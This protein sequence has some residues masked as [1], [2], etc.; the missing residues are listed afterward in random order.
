MTE[1]QLEII[2]K[3]VKEIICHQHRLSSVF[4]VN[5]KNQRGDLTID[6]E[7]WRYI[8]H[9]F[10]VNFIRYSD[11]LSVDMEKH[12]DQ[13][14]KVSAWRIALYLE[15]KGIYF[16]ESHIKDLLE[17]STIIDMC[18]G[19]YLLK[20]ASLLEKFIKKGQKVCRAR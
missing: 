20:K 7:R 13:P 15:S 6:T 10:G 14:D 9:G 19:F 1:P 8:K 16:E 17:S 11:E 12:I 5:A 3:S 18:D 2:E 4:L